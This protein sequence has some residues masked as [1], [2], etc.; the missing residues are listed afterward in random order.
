VSGYRAPYDIV[1]PYGLLSAVY[2][3]FILITSGQKMQKIIFLICLICCTNVLAI[4]K[5]PIIGDWEW[6]PIRGQCKETHSY[7]VDGTLMTKSGNQILTRTY[8]ITKVLG[9]TY[10]LEKKIISSNGGKD[11]LGYIN[12]FGPTKTT[13]ALFL[14]D[15]SYF[16]CASLDRKS[17]YGKATAKTL[18]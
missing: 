11:C 8:T 4:E 2:R 1:T 14:N 13:F 6:S 18:R 7:R 5:N 12:T 9:K 3:H 15:K 17:C 10:R 16:T